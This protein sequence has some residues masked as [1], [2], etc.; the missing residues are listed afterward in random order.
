MNKKISR[1]QALLTAIGFMIGS[2]IFFKADDILSSTNGSV[3]IAVIS[4]LIIG[5][6]LIFAGISV[7]A[8][9]SDTQ[10]DGGFIGYIEYH[11]SK[12][13]GK[14]IGR[15]IG[16]VIGWYQ[17]IVYTPM[18]VAVVS[19]V[20]GDYL[21][22]LFNFETTPMIQHTIGFVIIVAMFLW[23]SISAKIAALISATATVVK[24]F[25]LILLAIL[26]LVF[27]DPQNFTIVPEIVT[28][29]DASTLALI[30]AP[31]LSMAFA[32]DGWV[33]VGTLSQDMQNPK[34]DLPFVFMW[35]VIAAVIIYVGYFVG[36]SLLM[37]ASEIISLGNAHVSEI[38]K[39][40]FGDFGEKFIIAAVVVS[41]LG[42]CNAIFM[43]GSRYIYN[44]A[45]RDLLIGSD[46]FKQ[47]SKND[48]PFNAS[49][50]MIVVTMMYLLLYYLQATYTGES[51]FITN[52]VIDDIPMALN[53]MFY[54]ILFSINFYLYKQGRVGKFF[55]IVA[56]IIAIIGQVFIIVAFFSVNGIYAVGYLLISFVV[57]LLGFINVLTG[58]R[59][60]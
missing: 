1:N 38:A 29:S 19:I 8:I 39:G 10:V 13:F 51:V 44:M 45:T 37:P 35:S 31:M 30:F 34:K 24:M 25:P 32:F 50:F 40:L 47:K 55:G 36:V 54:L 17:I 3:L 4:W 46:F 60:I 21:L 52:V 57:I 59:K 58:G 42:T 5:T 20:F 2:G 18:F 28:E 11:M 43:A 7:A 22:Q 15:R 53:S 14:K 48:T 6:T 23:N 56:P 49:I 26:G 27:G 12:K 16:F 9:A 41:V 33:S